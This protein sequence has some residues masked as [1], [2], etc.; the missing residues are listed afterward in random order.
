MKFE[1]KFIG[2]INTEAYY[3]IEVDQEDGTILAYTVSA[4][5]IRWLNRM[6]KSKWE[7]KYFASSVREI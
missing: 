7:V 3:E 4:S 2:V 6:N 1:G 5:D